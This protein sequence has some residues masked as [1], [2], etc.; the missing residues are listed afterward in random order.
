[1][2][3]PPPPP[4]PWYPVVKL[5]GRGAPSPC[6]RAVQVVN[7]KKQRLEKPVDHFIGR[8]SRLELTP[9]AFKL[10]VTIGF[11]LYRGPTVR[12]AAVASRAASLLEVEAYAVSAA[13]PAAAAA[14]A[15]ARASSTNTNTDLDE[16]EGKPR[17][18]FTHTGLTNG[19]HS[20]LHT[21]HTTLPAARVV[22]EAAVAAVARPLLEVIANTRASSAAAA[23]TAA[24]V[25]AASWG[26]PVATSVAA[27][28]AQGGWRR[29]V[30]SPA[31]RRRS[32]SST[33]GA[34]R[35]SVSSGARRRSVAATRGGRPVAPSCR[36]RRAVPS[37][38]SLLLPVL[39][40]LDAALAAVDV[41]PVA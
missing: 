10:R 18:G 3:P 34:R 21:Q 28:G 23:V 38:G 36:R 12:E 40:H 37:G 13:E 2:P 19:R 15:A 31:R 5:A 4:P 25:T 9:G 29:S 16:D 32:V 27:Q 33:R 1:M 20:K 26:R 7:L 35:R 8:F 39:R 11:S 41:Q 17:H 30:S 6:C 22:R 14:A 24:A